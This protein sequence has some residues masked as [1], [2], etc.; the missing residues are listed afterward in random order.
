MFCNTFLT[1]LLLLLC[2]LTSFLGSAFADES[3]FQTGLRAYHLGQYQTAI[4][5][6]REAIG[7]DPENQ[8]IRY[9]L[10]NSLARNGDFFEAHQAYQRVITLSPESQ[11]ARLSRIALSGYGNMETKAHLW[12]DIKSSPSSKPVAGSPDRLYGLHIEG[13][14]YIK[15]V[16]DNGQY[17]RWS[18]HKLP[19]KLYIETSPP[20]IR[21]F[22]AGFASL[23]QKALDVWMKAL[24][25]RLSYVLVPSA[26]EADIRLKWVN[27]I[28]VNGHSTEQGTNY[29]AGITVPE[30]KNDQLRHMDV[31]LATFDIHNQP[32]N[33]ES[34]Y[35]IAVHEFGHALGLLGHSP[36]PEDIMCS[37]NHGVVT[38]SQ[39]DLNTIRTLYSKEADITNQPNHS[40]AASPERIEDLVER[41]NKEILQQE[42][43]PEGKRSHLDWLNLSSLYF[44]KGRELTKL[45]RLSPDKTSSAGNQQATALY[46]TALDDLAKSIQMEPADPIAY[47]N[48]TQV[49]QE[50]GQLDPSLVDIDKCLKL[51]PNEPNF[52][53]EKAWILA[54]MGRKSEA[55]IQLSNYLDRVPEGA[56]SPEVQLI[57]S[58]I[59]R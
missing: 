51:D 2:G 42:A 8:N 29:T 39:R 40:G 35:S 44:R 12:R 23:A 5:Y 31:K 52:Y 54:K 24:D 34:L 46:Q 48:R 17:V 38:P 21:N 10:A 20:G 19:I 45:A 26:E 36:Y 53:R 32:Q 55:E 47:Y 30:I 50:M 58:K 57:R 6:F 56:N 49:Y 22:E 16:A 28:D 11:A 27:T 4:V 25:N 13:G 15:H 18:V 14:D 33:D 7:K 43:I 9:Y 1:F 37:E 3:D 41:I 59:T